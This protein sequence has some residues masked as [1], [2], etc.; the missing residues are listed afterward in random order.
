MRIKFALAAVLLIASCGPPATTSEAPA[1]A[2]APEETSATD[3]PANLPAPPAE[4][5]AAPISAFTAV[6]PSELGVQA[7]PSVREA[8]TPLLSSDVN[9]GATLQLNVAESGEAA[10]ADVVRSGLEDDSVSAAQLRIEFRREP[11]GWYP[12]NAYR[13]TMCARGDNAGQWSATPCP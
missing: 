9:E 11:D 2:P 8:L 13:R 7:A 12:T 1:A 10:V 4:L 3:Q 5:V 6:E